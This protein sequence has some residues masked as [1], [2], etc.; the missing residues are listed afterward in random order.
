MVW[1]LF[2]CERL[3]LGVSI[4]DGN[5]ITFVINATVCDSQKYFCGWNTLKI[6]KALIAHK[7][8]FIRQGYFRIYWHFIASFV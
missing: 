3:N 4:F 6:D 2:I 5:E 1:W 7:S 8:R